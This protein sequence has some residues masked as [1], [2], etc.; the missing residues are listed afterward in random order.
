[1]QRG[2]REFAYAKSTCTWYETDSHQFQECQQPED[3]R[4]EPGV[5]RNHDFGRCTNFHELVVIS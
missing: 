5:E 1:V 3:L 2:L 4:N